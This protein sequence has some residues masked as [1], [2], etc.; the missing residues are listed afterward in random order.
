MEHERDAKGHKAIS[1]SGGAIRVVL[2]D[3]PQADHTWEFL[4]LFTQPAG[5]R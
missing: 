2:R 3:L 1:R 5:A 4:P